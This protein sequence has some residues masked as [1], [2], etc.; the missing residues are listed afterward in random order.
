VVHKSSKQ[1]LEIENKVKELY[2]MEDR[3]M[4]YD[5]RCILRFDVDSILI[6]PT[7]ELK[8]WISVNL[9]DLNDAMVLFCQVLH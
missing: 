2:A 8:A 3:G 5:R 6:L 9:Q 1:M 4:A 7:S